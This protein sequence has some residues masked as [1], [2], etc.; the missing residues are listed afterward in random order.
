MA[1]KKA[2]K[3]AVSAAS[4]TT[5]PAPATAT[6]PAAA[7]APASPEPPPAP[8]S[9]APATPAKVFARVVCH[10]YGRWTRGSIVEVTEKEYRR[11]GKK[12][13]LTKEDAEAARAAEEQRRRA[14]ADSPEVREEMEHQKAWLE[15]EKTAERIV[16]DRQLEAQRQARALTL[17]D[18]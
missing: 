10:Q 6:E 16:R 11:V 5:T 8:L 12:V 14:V 18:G 13:L 1:A 3:E 7:A 9:A 4:D 15:H 17:G 2:A